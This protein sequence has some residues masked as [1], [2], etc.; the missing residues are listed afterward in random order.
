MF[1]KIK[2]LMNPD[3][4][5]DYKG[6][7]IQKI[8]AGSQLYPLGENYCM[9]EYAGSPVTHRDIIEVSE[10]DHNALKTLMKSNQ[11][12]SEMDELKEK[13]K[14]MQKAIDDLIFGGMI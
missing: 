6:L 7:D 10:S 1:I 9:V 8:V 13:Q 11:P 4:N 5:V 3:G 2:N 12:K 14:L